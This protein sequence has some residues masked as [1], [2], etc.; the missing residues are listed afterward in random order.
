MSNE[1]SNLDGD[2]H[3]AAPSPVPPTSELVA[4]GAP[5]VLRD[6]SRV[7]VRQ[8][9]HSDREL[10]LRGFERLSPE[11]R[12]RRFLAPLTELT[13]G[14]VRY[15]TD[16]DHHD[17]EAIIALEEESGEGIGVARYVRE[18][19]HPHTAEVAVTV[20][21]DWQGRGVATLLLEVI[22]ARAREEG[23]H[24]F[25]ALMLASNKEMMDLVEHLGPVRIV[26]R[27]S[28]TVLVESRLPDVGLP[29]VLRKLLRVAARGDVAVPLAGRQLGQI[30]HPDLDSDSKGGSA[31]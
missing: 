19:D 12:Y 28:G 8:G 10:L 15:L 2:S 9:H 17:H 23:I 3:G 31:P 6:G 29:P 21:D 25:T 1:R 27:E 20:I 16:V 30:V 24:T 4:L 18:P 5:A 7:R 13:D 26:D 11:S 22:A 14:M